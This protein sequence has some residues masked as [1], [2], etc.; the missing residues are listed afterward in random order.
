MK[1]HLFLREIVVLVQNQ[2]FTRFALIILF[3]F[4][5]PN[6]LSAVSKDSGNVHLNNEVIIYVSS[7]A[8]IYGL[9]AGNK[10]K[11]VHL[12]NSSQTN[13]KNARVKKTAKIENKKFLKAVFKK[14]GVYK[15]SK[16]SKNI[17]DP[18]CKDSGSN[19][20]VS[21]KL[22]SNNSSN[23]FQN[24]SKFQNPAVFSCATKKK[25]IASKI[26]FYYSHAR[27]SFGLFQIFKLRPPPFI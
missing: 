19:T 12:P 20:F 24:F 22:S 1:T 10:V 6:S 8:L 23:D 14:E 15:K 25:I 13:I 4:V 2:L 17:Y 11:I 27:N 21:K 18:F 3:L 9:E 16:S 7:N 5:F 26:F